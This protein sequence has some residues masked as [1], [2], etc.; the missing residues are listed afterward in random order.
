MTDGPS[1][2]P[3]QIL[4]ERANALHPFSKAS[5]VLDNG[6]GPGV[7][8]TG[9]LKTHGASLPPACRLLCSD[10]S[11][12]M[13]QQVQAT[14]SAAI[15]A[16]DSLWPRVGTLVSN[17]MDMA[18]VPSAAYSH[19][20]AGW[21]YFMTPDPQR[22]L[23]ESRRVLGDGGVLACS[24][25][26]GNQWMDAMGEMTVVRP[27]IKLP[28]I[29][30]EWGSAEAVKGELEKAGF[31]DVRSERVDVEM[32]YETHEKLVGTLTRMPHTLAMMKGMSEEETSSAK[33]A[34]LRKCRKF[35][36]NEP[37]TLKGV[38]IVAVGRK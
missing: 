16:G 27:D 14:K 5:G 33:E 20:L 15:K 9:V 10:F 21:V 35:N 4:L 1:A 26:E 31:T 25:W 17:A 8:M 18:A 29:P 24:A 38:A 34:I 37:G 36:P 11:D 19:V 22:C 13:I 30:K 32:G 6:C 3:V 7:L 28:S 23:A 12:G 2:R